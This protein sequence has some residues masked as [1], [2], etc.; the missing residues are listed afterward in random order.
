MSGELI[1]Q[2]EASQFMAMIEKVVMNPDAS[3][4]KLEK[5]LDMQERIL[6]RNA[7]QAFTADLAAMQCDL[8]L[9]KENGKSHN[10]AYALLEDINQAIRPSLQKFGF[11]VTF[12]V[13]QAEKTVTVKAI[14][15]HRGGHSE[16]TSM[17]LPLDISGNKTA[18]QQVGSTVSYGKRYTISALLNISTGDDSD[19]NNQ[20]VK[21]IT[22][23]QAKAIK[24][25]LDGKTDETNAEFVATFGP[26][27]RITPEERAKAA[28]W[29]RNKP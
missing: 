25:I 18:T 29:L 11:A 14:L 27:D 8:P 16:Y 26:H 7:H 15:S 28:A 10:G 2:N 24:F 22:V 17:M 19:G 1:V 21:T 4:D 23:E 13:E 20:A 6:N 3:I 9:V 12:R 5:M